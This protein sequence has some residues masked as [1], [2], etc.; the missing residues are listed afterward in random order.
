[1]SVRHKKLINKREDIH[2]EMIEGYIAAY[3]E[4]IQL[5]DE[6]LITRKTPKSAK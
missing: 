5:T 2:S 4:I 1:M 6:G 3:P